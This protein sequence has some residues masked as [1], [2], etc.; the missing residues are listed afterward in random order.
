MTDGIEN[1]GNYAEAY[2]DGLW[3]G[4]Y[5]GQQRAADLLHMVEVVRRLPAHRRAQGGSAG[6]LA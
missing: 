4:R 1:F 6:N 2:V 5:R 3:C